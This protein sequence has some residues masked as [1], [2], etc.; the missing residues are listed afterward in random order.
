MLVRFL[1]QR[2][3][4][5]LGHLVKIPFGS[6]SR[7]LNYPYKKW[8]LKK[9]SEEVELCSAA[10]RTLRCLRLTM[11]GTSGVVIVDPLAPGA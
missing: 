3:R 7:Q 8:Q 11:R 4:Q 2:S 1:L 10:V 9:E 6:L 5:D